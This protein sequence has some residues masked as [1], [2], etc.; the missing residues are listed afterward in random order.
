MLFPLKRF[1]LLKRLFGNY[2]ERHVYGNIAV[3]LD[4]SCVV[5]HFFDGVERDEFAVHVVAELF[6]SFCNLDSVYRAENSAG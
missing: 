3:K 1:L 4:G 2:S 6:E 5:A